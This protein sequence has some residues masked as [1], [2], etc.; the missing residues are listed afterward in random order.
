MT[1]PLATRVKINIDTQASVAKL[2]NIATAIPDTI[3]V[4]VVDNEG[5]RVNA[6]SIIGM[7]YAM[8]FE[9]I[10]LESDADVYQLF[11]EFVILE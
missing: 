1:K 9:E 6:R 5:M 8:T 11:E 3:H 10:W 2:V 4:E 7:L